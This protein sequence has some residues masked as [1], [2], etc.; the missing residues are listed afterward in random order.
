M[1]KKTL[2]FW[3]RRLV[4][5]TLL[6]MSMIASAGINLKTSADTKLSEVISVI[7]S[8]SDYE[9]FYDDAIAS[10]KVKAVSFKD[11][12]VKT[13]LTKHL[14]GQAS[15]ILLKIRLFILNRKTSPV[16]KTH[17]TLGQKKLS[18]ANCLM[19]MESR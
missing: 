12:D 8:Q 17:Q 1:I 13:V 5:G 11:A 7:T 9:F 15:V 4:T 3:P 18:Q 10:H 6:A 14:Q 19:K 2:S 16:L